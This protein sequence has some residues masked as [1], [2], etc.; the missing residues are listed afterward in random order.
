MIFFVPIAHPMQIAVAGVH[1]PIQRAIYEVANA[2][3]AGLCNM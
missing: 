3:V 1:G 2:I